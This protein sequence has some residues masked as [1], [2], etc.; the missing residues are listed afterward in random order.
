MTYSTTA[1]LLR[2]RSIRESDRLYTVLTPDRGKLELLGQGTRKSGSKLAG[3]MAVPGILELHCVRG[4]AV[5]RL[6]GVEVV[7]RIEWTS[8]PQRAAAQA[9]LDLVDKTTK[10]G[11]A[12][13]T[14]F[15]LVVSVADVLAASSAVAGL[16][17]ELDTAA[18]RLLDVLGF[19]PRLESCY[20]CGRRDE[21]AVFDA[22]GGGA[23]CASCRLTITDDRPLLPLPA[24]T[25]QGLTAYLREHFGE[26]WMGR[27]VFE[28]I[29]RV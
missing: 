8:L 21:L 29:S 5:D 19:R 16:T 22:R 27:K 14:L 20:E 26:P 2:T 6:A 1:I 3:G 24:H 7:R 23:L 4:K 13:R 25:A 10:H 28:E 18:W 15:D 9:M 11:K 12:D 17:K